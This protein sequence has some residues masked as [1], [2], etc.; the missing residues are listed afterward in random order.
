M[1]VEAAPVASG[2]M[3]HALHLPPFR[4][5]SSPGV[6]VDLARAA[7]AGGWDGFF[8]WDHVVRP[9]EP[10]RVVAAD[11]WILLAAVATVTDRIRLGPMVT[12]LARRRP[13]KVARESVTL[14]HLSGG[15]L[16]LGVGLGVDS[17]GELAR[18][19]EL[20][21]PRERAGAYD[22]ALALLRELWSG[23]E[24]DHHGEH[25]TA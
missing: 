15:R 23:E 19:G 18:F 13:Q 17:G 3:R 2:D 5:Y 6:V 22:E 9:H 11:P 16:T 7:E 24:V 12:P 4:A 25:Y 1:S 21:D 14:D 8:T 20:D 10:E